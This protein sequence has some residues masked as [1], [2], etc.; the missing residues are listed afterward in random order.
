[1]MCI[2][3]T[4]LGMGPHSCEWCSRA[5]HTS[6]PIPFA[7]PH[8]TS[9]TSLQVIAPC[10]SQAKLKAFEQGPQDSQWKMGKFSKVTSK[11]G[12]QG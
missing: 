2:A 8:L 7:P 4:Q 1:M 5:P 3:P 9:S 6:R 12:A 11:I 10:P